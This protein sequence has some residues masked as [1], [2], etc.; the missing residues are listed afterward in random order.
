MTKTTLAHKSTVSQ[1]RQRFDDDVERFSNLQ[2]GQSSTVD[3]PLALE[4]IT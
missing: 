2:T 4:L 3:A 1:I